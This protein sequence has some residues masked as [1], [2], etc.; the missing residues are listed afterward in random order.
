MEPTNF[1]GRCPPGYLPSWIYDQGEWWIDRMGQRRAL[2]MLNLDELLKAMNLIEKKA[3]MAWNYEVNVH[4]GFIRLERSEGRQ[5]CF[6]DVRAL[7]A[8]GP[9]KWLSQTRLYRELQRRADR[10]I[11]E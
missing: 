2:E 10:I 7:I 9:D 3:Q 5:P 1:P 6:Q 4:L 8:Q 11:T